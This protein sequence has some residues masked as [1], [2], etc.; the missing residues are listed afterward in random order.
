MPAADT[1]R[2]VTDDDELAAVRTALLEEHARLTS[3][4]A[5]LQAGLEEVIR[6]SATGSG[7]DQ[8]DSGANTFGREHEQV[9]LGRVGE[10]MDQTEQALARIAAGSYGKCESCGNSIGAPRLEAYP[11]AILCV[12]CKQRAERR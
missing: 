6:G 8:A 10:A 9:L 5:S 7:A 1:A 11:R 4:R 12:A 2:L 3:E